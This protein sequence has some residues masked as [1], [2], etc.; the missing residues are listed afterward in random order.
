MKPPTRDADP[1]PEL[2]VHRAIDP[3][4]H[5]VLI[6]DSSDD[7]PDSLGVMI[8]LESAETEAMLRDDLGGYAQKLENVLRAIPEGMSAQVILRSSRDIRPPIAKWS[9]TSTAVDPILALLEEAR[10]VRLASFVQ[11]T[12]RG[13]FAA[14]SLHALFTLRRPGSWRD[15]RAGPLD[16]I[17]SLFGGKRTEA[18]V[19][20][21][22]DDDRKKL[23]EV[24]RTVEMY[25]AQAGVKASRL[26]ED[27]VVQELYA[28]LNP[29][30]S[31]YLPPPSKRPGERLACRVALS[32]IEID[33][34]S[35]VVKVDRSYLAVVS[36]TQFPVKTAAAIL[37][38]STILEAAPEVDV[39]LNLH[40][41]EQAAL[42][43][44]I[45]KKRRLAVNQTQDPNQRAVLS[46]IAGELAEME[47]DLGSGDRL[48]SARLHVLV[49]SRE[50]KAVL[51]QARA[52]QAG[53]EGAGFRAIVEDALAGSLWF[54]SLPLSYR[55]D[56]D[57]R[58]RRSRT[59]LATNVAHVLPLHGAMKGTP[60]GAQ[61]LLN[62]RGEPVPLG[63]FSDQGAPHAIV[64][65][66]PGSGKS[67]YANDLVLNALRS[68]GRAWVIDRGGS[69]RKLAEMVGGSAVTF[70]VAR[71]K[72]INPCGTAPEDGS[73]PPETNE[74]LRDWIAEMATGGE[75]RDLS[76]HDRNLLSMA[77]RAAFQAKA[78][79]EVR[80]S[81]IRQALT[82]MAPEHPRTK[83]LAV[84]L[85]E[86]AN[87]GPY[88]RFFD[89]QDEVD[90]S[91][92]FVA[93]DLA[94]AAMSKAV[95]SS[96]LM[97]IM[98]RIMLEA[99]R[100]PFTDKYLLIDEA[101][102]LL[103]SET[104]ARFLEN[105]ARTARKL[106][107]SLV[108]ISQQVTDLDG[109]SGKAIL[110]EARYQVFFRQDE[111][112]IAPAAA[113]LGLSPAEVELYRS[114]KTV[115]GRWSECFVR[116]EYTKGV[117]RLVLDPVS[118]WLTTSDPKDREYLEELEAEE[119]EKGKDSRAALRKALM[120]A[121][122]KRPI[123]G[124]GSSE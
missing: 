29:T 81:D 65:G 1:Y 96:L 39:I 93:I 44:S 106:R 51:D 94:N 75:T 35:G 103:K 102:T 112:A 5:V 54:Q 21:F 67:V 68:G 30:R 23:T 58:I 4:G 16:A 115:W 74:A 42:R 61:I 59:V 60:S 122:L 77:V 89:G 111:S 27:G 48:I 37:G 64:T 117:A 11:P 95:A 6:G 50:E 7:V 9:A 26:D 100:D 76:V 49:R 8:R 120:R 2:L 53:L 18:R 55:P 13:V 119:R 57:R 72:R 33:P 114:L 84:C 38:A 3:D 45:E 66:Q 15:L 19:G 97:A 110:H 70:D 82:A 14:R 124:S 20:H 41:P 63:F 31:V 109:P 17:R 12:D 116:S 10:K 78:G 56:L 52:V 118:Y 91:N 90:F 71:P 46:G 87:P 88:G 34:D 121:A 99:A 24:A 40:V 104:T 28:S 69:Y 108:I 80:V 83:E 113:L 36:V 98:H 62:R 85:A 47:C 86:Y 32:P 123:G 107:L 25:F 79:R 92:R 43:A 22:Y 101:W 105:A 73:C